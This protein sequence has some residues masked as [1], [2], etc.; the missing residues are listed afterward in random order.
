MEAFVFV[1]LSLAST[2]ANA[3]EAGGPPRRTIPPALLAEVSAVQDRFEL[4]LATDC[5]AGLCFSRGCS[6]VAH[7]VADRPPASSL[8]GLGAEPGPSAVD[9]QAWLTQ[10]RCEF[11]YETSLEAGA[12]QALARRLQTKVSSGYTVVSVGSQALPA[13]PTLPLQPPVVDATTEA[14]EP[15]AAP[16]PSPLRELWTTLLDDFDWMIGLMLGT[17]AVMALIWAWRRV[18]RESLEERALLAD[19]N[20][21]A[22][23][24]ATPDAAAP[25]AEA[26]AIDEAVAT[27]LAAWRLR[28]SG[29]DAFHPDPELQGMLRDLLR[30]GELPLLAKAVL[31]F[32]TLPG[33]FPTGGD[34]ATDKLALSEYLKTVDPG[35]LPS[36][37]ELFR[38]L[39]RHTSS[40]TLA[41]QPDAELVR[42]LRDDFGAAGLATL[43]AKIP[44][45]TG[46]LLFALA[47]GN[48]HQELVHLLTP[49]Q[50]VTMSEQLLRSNRLDPSETQ[51]LFAVLR[52]ARDPGVS[53]AARAPTEV[54]DRGSIFDAP[55]ALSALLPAVGPQACSDLFMSSLKRFGGNLPDWYAEILV[56]EMLFYLSD[57]ARADL[58]L[59]S[60]ADALAGWLSLLDPAVSE[61]TLNGAPNALRTSVQAA[62]AFPSR[63]RQ[64]ALADRGRRELATGFQAQLARARVRFEDVVRSLAE[65]R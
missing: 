26:P 19:L 30:A 37:G 16:P 59:G 31:T 10:A 46:A 7:F 50:M 2:S 18:G 15:L 23:A 21:E 28:L 1:I 65:N 6:Y 51:Y 17:F 5:G 63:A 14:P 45:R 56:P 12:V 52:A 32:P 47:P 44:P 25:E 58:L 20:R 62:S 39:N 48:A 4:A 64:I 22:G 55:S 36:D 34:I 43:I 38:A 60:D 42:S 11:A 33:L 29:L 41:A 61:R 57:E 35:A 9:S 27:Q 13:L 40:A 3:Q 8:P 53:L 24:V 54:S 49:S